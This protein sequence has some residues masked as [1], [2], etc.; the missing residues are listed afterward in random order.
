MYVDALDVRREPWPATRKVGPPM[1]GTTGAARLVTG[2]FMGLFTTGCLAAGACLAAPS[3]AY[4]DQNGNGSHN[5]NAFS[6]HSPTRN[7]GLQVVSNANA[8]GIT[9][10]RN[11]FCKRLRSCRIHQPH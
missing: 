5:H 6:I 3:P 9:F 8:G 1:R 10:T 7:T 11:A 4:A 2:L